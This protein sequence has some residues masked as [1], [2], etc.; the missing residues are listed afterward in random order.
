MATDPRTRRTVEAEMGGRSAVLAVIALQ[1]ASRSSAWSGTGSSGGSTGGCG[2]SP[3]CRRRSCSSRLPGTRPGALEQIGHRR[4]VALDAARGDQRRHRRRACRPDRVA[5]TGR[6]RA[7]ASCCSR[8]TIWGT[9]VITYGLWF[10]AIRPRRPGQT[11]PGGPAAA[12]LPVS[13]DGEPRP[14]RAGLVSAALRLHLRVLHELGR[15][16]PDRRDAAHT[17]D[18]A[19]DALESAVSALTILLVAARAVNIFK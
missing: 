19:D 1:L 8:A 18:E 11:R 7:A 12:R 3:S 16:Q 10:W 5:V 15:L 17:P 9:N 14:C 6:R 13:A 4:N 2:R